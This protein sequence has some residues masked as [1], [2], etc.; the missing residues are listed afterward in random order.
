MSTLSAPPVEANRKSR[1]RRTHLRESAPVHCSIRNRETPARPGAAPKFNHTAPQPLLQVELAR[2][3]HGFVIMTRSPEPVR[4]S[5][6]KFP[7]GCGLRSCLR[8]SGGHG[9][10]AWQGSADALRVVDGH[11][12]SKLLPRAFLKWCRLP[13]CAAE[14]WFRAMRAIFREMAELS[15]V[16]P[17]W[18]N[19]SLPERVPPSFGNP[20]EIGAR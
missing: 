20:A 3:D 1:P 19:P 2:P 5:A 13:G 12:G 14:M 15:T 10:S 18:M 16:S 17:A 7:Y 6:F 8:I 4:F 11:H 9:R